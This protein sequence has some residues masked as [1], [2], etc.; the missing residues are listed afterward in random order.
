MKPPD[1]SESVMDYTDESQ[2]MPPCNLCGG[3]NHE[4]VFK[5]NIGSFDY[6]RFS[7]YHAYGD[8]YRCLDCGLTA[9][10]LSHNESEILDLLRSEKYLDE[11]IGELNLREKKVFFQWLI[12]FIK[13]I[14]AVDDRFVLDVG[15]NTGVFL[16]E[17]KP[18]TAKLYGVEPSDEAAE[19]CSVQGLEV[20][21]AVIGQ[22]DLPDEFFDIAVLWDVVEHLYDPNQDIQTIFRKLKP[23][24]F[25]FI[26]THDID[27]LFARLTGAKYPMLMYQ[28]FFHFSRRSLALMLQ[29]AGF[30]VIK[31]KGF[32][33]SW[34]LGYLYHLLEKLWPESTPSR[35]MQMCMRP[36]SLNPRL[37]S[38]QA[39]IPIRNFFIMAARRPIDKTLDGQ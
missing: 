36:I 12:D 13:T 16:N 11:A 14:T 38:I 32:M 30:E 20:Q 22:A 10:R 8:I 7:Q 39:P 18:Y 28:H 23:G 37:A 9:Q 27:G 24:G 2:V 5:G 21:N 26:S 31:I 6:N 35:I 3:R 25:I 33:K 4:L 1:G 19:H 17:L 15:A 29:K 34:S